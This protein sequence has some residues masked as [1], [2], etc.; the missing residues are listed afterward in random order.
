MDRYIPSNRITFIGAI[1]LVIFVFGGGLVLGIALYYLERASGLIVVLPAIAGAVGGIGLFYIL[2]FGKIRNPYLAILSAI[3]LGILI[4]GTPKYISYTNFRDNIALQMANDLRI[5]NKPHDSATVQ[6]LIDLALTRLAGNP[7]FLGYLVYSA[8][9]GMTLTFESMRGGVVM[10]PIEVGLPGWGVY[11]SW[12][13][14]ASLAIGL[15][16]FFAYVK[17]VAPYSE[18]GDAWFDPY[19]HFIGRVPI[20]QMQAFRDYLFMGAYEEAS[21]LI[22]ANEEAM[23]PC[24]QIAVQMCAKCSIEDVFL[25]VGHTTFVPYTR[26]S[27]GKRLLKVKQKWIIRKPITPAQLEALTSAFE[28]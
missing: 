6:R 11:I 28:E 8:Q 21:K 26:R 25:N 3:L 24:L 12:L 4:Y 16:I 17:S 27:D 7:G 1:T 19:K 22:V 13:L 23:P 20:E 14:E 18:R 10:P 2:K 9:Q 15:P 5:E